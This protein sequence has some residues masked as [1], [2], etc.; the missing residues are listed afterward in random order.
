MGYN[1]AIDATTNDESNI[2]ATFDVCGIAPEYEHGRFERPAR[3]RHRRR[4]LLGRA[5]SFIGFWR[6]DRVY[7]TD[8][9]IRG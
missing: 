5:R 1:Y 8:F 9:E 4:C 3:Y 6:D 2:G 7:Y